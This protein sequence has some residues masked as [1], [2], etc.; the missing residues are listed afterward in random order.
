MGR[1]LKELK[2]D[3][4]KLKGMVR[5]MVTSHNQEISGRPSDPIED[6][7]SKI[8]EELPKEE[9]PEENLI[10]VLVPG[11]SFHV[12]ETLVEIPLSPCLPL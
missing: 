10:L 7:F 1:E 8:V 11:L 12:P 6:E 5:L 2:E 3:F 9:V 4:T